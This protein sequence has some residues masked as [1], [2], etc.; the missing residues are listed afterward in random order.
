MANRIILGYS[1]FVTRPIRVDAA[2][3]RMANARSARDGGD[4]AVMIPRTIAFLAPAALVAALF[5]IVAGCGED[6]PSGSNGNNDPVIETI[7]VSPDTVFQDDTTSVSVTASDADGD[8]LTYSYFPSGG[9]VSGTGPN[10]LWVAPGD[11]GGYT[12]LATVNDGRGGIASRSASLAVVNRP[13]GITGTII[14]VSPS[15]DLGGSRLALYTTLESWQ[16]NNP[17]YEEL[18][19]EDAVNSHSFSILY[20]PVGLYYLDVWKDLNENEVKD[21]ADLY[22][23]YGTGALPE[24]DLQAIP[25]EQNRTTHL[26]G[27]IQVS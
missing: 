2:G 9:S 7:V 16:G 23:F 6:S 19:P 3:A 17:W 26:V 4:C 27:S 18:I 12:L 11:V 24:P 13:A 25:V 15:G 5:L 20:L 21:V 1:R 22:G 8:S 14:L 10:V